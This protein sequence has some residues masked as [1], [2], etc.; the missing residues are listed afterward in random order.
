MVPLS[1]FDYNKLF[2]VVSECHFYPLVR[3]G[4]TGLP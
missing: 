2:S 4:L 3:H 1:L